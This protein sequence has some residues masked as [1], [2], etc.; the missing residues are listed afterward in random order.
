MRKHGV[1]PCLLKG[2]GK[3][4]GC[5]VLAGLPFGF[6]IETSITTIRLICSGV[7]V[8]YP[9]L[10]M[11]IRRYAEGLP[12]LMHCINSAYDKPWFDPE[13][14]PNLKSERRMKS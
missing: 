1:L 6:G 13:A 2:A 10:K 7:L 4:G 11:L 9:K 5:I 3:G 14:T 12:F 8:W